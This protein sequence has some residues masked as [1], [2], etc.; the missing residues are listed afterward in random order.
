MVDVLF[1]CANSCD[2]YK[3]QYYRCYFTSVRLLPSEY[4]WFRLVSCL[5]CSNFSTTCYG[6][7]FMPWWCARSIILDYV[8]LE[9]QWME[10]VGR[11]EM[12]IHKVSIIQY[13]ALCHALMH[14]SIFIL[15][16]CIVS[17]LRVS[18]CECSPCFAVFSI[19]G[20]V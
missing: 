3:L 2:E 18:S 6:R 8:R 7:R 10:V 9:W 15:Y 1:L 13:Y 17:E 11:D 5:S 14:W 16:L 20:W 12:K 19:L 4:S